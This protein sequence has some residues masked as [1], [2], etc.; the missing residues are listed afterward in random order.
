MLLTNSYISF[1]NLDHRKDRLQRMLESLDKVGIEA[2]RTRGMLPSEYSG[3]PKRV[4]VMQNR[5]PGA[6]GCH[7]SQLSIMQEAHKRDQ[8]AFVMEDDLIFCS[9]F[10]KRISWIERFISHH[11]W[12][13]IWLGAM[14]HVHPPWWH[15]KD[16]GRDAEITDDPWIMRTYGAFSTHCYIVNKESLHKVL[17]MLDE[18]LDTTI[19]ID[20]SFI[21]MQPHLHTYTF[22]PGCVIQYDNQS[23]IGKGQTIFSNFKKLGPYWFQDTLDGFDPRVFNWHEAAVKSK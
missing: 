15:K 3:N 21:Q 1:V 23:N 16:L 5:T 7:F 11:P 9:D 13:V 6:I 20:Y 14:F 8:H 10:L 19:G 12:D 4:E 18:Q 17:V 22:V 2:V